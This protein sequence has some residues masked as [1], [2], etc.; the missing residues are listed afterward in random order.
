MVNALN[1]ESVTLIVAG[2]SKGT[3]A[4]LYVAIILDGSDTQ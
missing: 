3:K 2:L 4:A 1:G